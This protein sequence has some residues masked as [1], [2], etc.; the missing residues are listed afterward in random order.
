MSVI[1]VLMYSTR[2]CTVSERAPGP[3]R[4]R[5]GALAPAR[6]LLLRFGPRTALCSLKQGIW[7]AECLTTPFCEG[8]SELLLPPRPRREQLISTTPG[9]VSARLSGWTMAIW[10]SMITGPAALALRS[11]SPRLSVDA[12]VTIH[13][14]IQTCFQWPTEISIEQYERQN[15]PQEVCACS[16]VGSPI[17]YGLDCAAVFTPHR[18]YLRNIAMRSQHRASHHSW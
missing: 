14:S 7:N 6:L 9:F 15:E 8:T 16:H 5:E 1:A 10:T 13:V 17:P 4:L 3:T 18:H 2:L 12:H 11:G